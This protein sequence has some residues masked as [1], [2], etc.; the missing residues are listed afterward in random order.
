MRASP[1][2]WRG[3]LPAGQTGEV[4]TNLSFAATSMFLFLVSEKGTEKADL[5][6]LPP[7]Y[8]RDSA[9][10]RRMLREF[11]FGKARRAPSKRTRGGS[12]RKLCFRR[13]EMRTAKMEK[14]THV[15]S[16]NFLD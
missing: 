7:K 5:G 16:E 2:L 11:A 13:L 1:L 8:P 10:Y 3:W 12:Y 6:R 14:L 4:R 15:G 9:C